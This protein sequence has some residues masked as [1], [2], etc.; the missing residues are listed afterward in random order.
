MKPREY[1]NAEYYMQW[2]DDSLDK[3]KQYKKLLK[4]LKKNYPDAAMA[5]KMLNEGEDIK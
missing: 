2:L 3:E 1:H 5:W 4:F